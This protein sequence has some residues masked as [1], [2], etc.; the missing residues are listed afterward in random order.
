MPQK[1]KSPNTQDQSPVP[2]MNMFL[3]KIKQSTSH[4]EGLKIAIMGCVVNGPGEMA[5]ADYGYVGS[6]NGKVT[7]YYGHEVVK[8]NIPEDQSIEELVSLIKRK[9]DWKD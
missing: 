1:S 5:D 9:G 8:K 6:G 3:E 2:G 7:L 4:L